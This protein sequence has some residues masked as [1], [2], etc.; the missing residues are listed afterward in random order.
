MVGSLGALDP[1]RRFAG[2]RCPTLVV[3]AELDPIPIEWSRLLASTTP[4]ADFKVIPGANH[5][6]MIEDAESLRSAVLP[7][8]RSHN[9]RSSASRHAAAG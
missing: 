1:M 9:S 8:L 3:H 4:A 2:I 5:F 6:S 7:W